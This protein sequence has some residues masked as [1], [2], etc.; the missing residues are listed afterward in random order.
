MM[1]QGY[2]LFKSLSIWED[3]LFRGTLYSGV[4]ST[5]DHSPALGRATFLLLLGS[6]LYA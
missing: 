2:S 6:Y 4:L 5:Q 1:T 3:S